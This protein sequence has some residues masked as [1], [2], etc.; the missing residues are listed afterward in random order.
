VCL[1]KSKQYNA[2]NGLVPDY[3]ILFVDM[4]EHKLEKDI[5]IYSWE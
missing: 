1:N 4:S 5:E 2:W 3:S